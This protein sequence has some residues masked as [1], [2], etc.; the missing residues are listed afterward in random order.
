MRVRS[1]RPISVR[2]NE[3]YR[4]HPVIVPSWERAVEHPSRRSP[5]TCCLGQSVDI[6]YKLGVNAVTVSGHTKVEESWQFEI[7]VAGAR[8]A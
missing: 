7:P 1:Y 5:V 2:Q 4:S 6:I 8:D 3:C